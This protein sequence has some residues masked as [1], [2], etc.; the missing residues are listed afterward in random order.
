MEPAHASVAPDLE[1]EVVCAFVAL[2]A[3]AAGCGRWGFILRRRLYGICGNAGDRVVSQGCVGKDL[4]VCDVF[5]V[6]VCTV[7]RDKLSR[8]QVR[9]IH[10]SMSCV[11]DV[12][13]AGGRA[14]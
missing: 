3:Y 13:Y 11:R 2:A 7:F 12:V 10:H 4:L 5:R 1:A 9:C 6:P 14:I 8:V